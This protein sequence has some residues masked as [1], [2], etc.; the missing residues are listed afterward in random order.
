MSPPRGAGAAHGAASNR[1]LVTRRTGSAYA[2][3]T[4]REGLPGTSRDESSQHVTCGIARTGHQARSQP[5]RGRVS[6]NDFNGSE[7]PAR[8]RGADAG[9]YPE[10]E[11]W[12][13]DG[14]WRD[15]S[16]DSDYETGTTSA[17]RPRR[18]GGPDSGT[19]GYSY[20]AD[21]KGWENAP[22]SPP[23]GSA[24]SGLTATRSARRAAHRATARLAAA[25]VTGTAATGLVAT[26]RRTTVPA[27]AATVPGWARRPGWPGRTG[28][29]WWSRRPPAGR[30]WRA[31]RTPRPQRRQGQGQLV[32]A[33]DVEEGG[34]PRRRDGRPGDPAGRRRLL[35]RLQQRHDPDAAR[36]QRPRPELDRL[37]QRRQDAHRHDRPDRPAGLLTLQP[38]PDA[39]AGR[40]DRGRGPQLLDRGRHLADRHPAR[41]L[42]RR[43][44]QRRQ[45][46]RRFDDHAGVRQAATTATSGP[47]RRSA[48]RSRRSSSRRSWPSPSPSS[49]S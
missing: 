21:G 19:P 13:Q 5:Q 7:R 41:G 42:R 44:E 2:A 28:R 34:R 45:P 43:D 1:R 17:V 37:L 31:R 3:L 6:S 24:A 12:G 46:L 32:A 35:L 20:W 49:G 30:S 48:G 33:L 15:P 27:R 10:P 40:G 22:G 23:H 29:P 39:G 25:R 11:G 9:K 8:G 47:S 26:R 18:S 14:F 16:I 4:S 36:R 38:D